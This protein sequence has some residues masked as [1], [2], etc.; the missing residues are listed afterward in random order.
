MDSQ[1]QSAEVEAL[2]QDVI[3]AVTWCYL[4]SSKAPRP[5]DNAS[6]DQAK[7]LGLL[8]QDPV[9]G[10][11]ERGIGAL[12]AAGLMSGC[13]APATTGVYLLWARHEG[14]V[15]Q[16]QCI[17]SFPE[18]IYEYYPEHTAHLR[19]Q[20]EDDYRSFF[21]DPTEVC[22]FFTTYTRVVLPARPEEPDES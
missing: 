17:G 12:I 15:R 20:L 13:P 3:R 19:E 4:G 6:F 5:D 1:P 11:T 7:K 9:W 18:A 2:D 21:D 22:E 16:D 8:V 14:D 10:A